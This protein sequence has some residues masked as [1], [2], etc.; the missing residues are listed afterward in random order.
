MPT[1][2]E[3]QIFKFSELSDDA[4]QKAIEYF[5]QN[6]DFE[7]SA[8]HVIDN[9]KEIAERFGLYIDKIYYSGFWN[10]GDGASFTGSYKYKKGALAEIIKEYPTYTEL[11]G[12]VKRLQ[13]AQRRGFYRLEASINTSGNYCHA[14]SM[15]I[16]VEDREEPYKNVESLEDDITEELR[17]YAN[18]IYKDLRDE[19]EYQ[20][21]EEAITENIESNDYDFLEDGELA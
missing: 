2:R 4:K 17:D 16:S 3:V 14:Y 6:N 20:T 21:S 19:Y 15:R 18:L 12:L 10:Q 1:I 8:E 13:E 9:A 7:Y 11:H 5:A